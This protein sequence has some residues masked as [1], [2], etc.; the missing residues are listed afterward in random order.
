[1]RQNAP[2]TRFRILMI[3]APSRSV[4]PWSLFM[5]LCGSGFGRSGFPFAGWMPFAPLPPRGPLRAVLVRHV[6]G[7]LGRTGL[8]AA[9][10]APSAV[11]QVIG[12][13]DHAEW[14]RRQF[15]PGPKISSLAF[16]RDRR[17]PI[18]SCCR[19]HHNP[20]T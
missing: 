11:D 17:P 12:L 2:V 14:K 3:A 7:P 9:G 5:C 20:H 6:Q 16:G 19:E 18:T 1:M 8:I 10:V 13:V 4:N 15:A